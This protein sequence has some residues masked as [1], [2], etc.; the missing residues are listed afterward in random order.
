MSL[1]SNSDTSSES[2]YDLD[3]D[4][5]SEID[6]DSDNEALEPE[7]D[8]PD[9]EEFK[10]APWDPTAQLQATQLDQLYAKQLAELHAD[11]KAR[12]ELPVPPYIKLPRR[13]PFRRFDVRILPDYVHSLIHYFE[14]FWG[15]EVWVSL[16]RNTNAY[17]KY[18][19][20]WGKGNKGSGKLRW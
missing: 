3:Q 20:A 2:E 8:A 11:I 12:A 5:I 4:S 9:L 7:R 1:Y 19:E 16:V 14:L 6:E 15:P 18:K 13:W 10:N 17:A